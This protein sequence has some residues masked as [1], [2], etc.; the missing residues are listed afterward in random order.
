MSKQQICPVRF[1][2]WLVLYRLRD[3]DGPAWFLVRCDCGNVHAVRANSLMQGV[4]RSCGCLTRE[5]RGND[6]VNAISSTA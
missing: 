4:S 5:K 2:R 1:D 3:M 6:S